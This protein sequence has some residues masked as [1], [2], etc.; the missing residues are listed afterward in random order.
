MLAFQQNYCDLSLV[1]EAARNV[2]RITAGYDGDDLFF[3]FVGHSLGGAAAQCLAGKKPN[4]RSIAFNGGAAA[5]NPVLEGPGPSRA[6]FYHI[7][8]DMISTHMSP[9]AAKVVRVAKK[10]KGFGVLYPHS[11]ARFLARDGFWEY[12]TADQEDE[13][14]R[15]YGN[16][17]GWFGRIVNGIIS[18]VNYIRRMKLPAR[19]PIPGSSR[20]KIQGFN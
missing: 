18:F 5:T 17:S 16:G 14:W 10:D 4:S 19:S 11:S 3:V 1:E 9:Q 12:A 13:A 2:D 6:T 7:F 15:V 8:G 20:F